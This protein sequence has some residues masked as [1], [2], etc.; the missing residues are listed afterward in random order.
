MNVSA[1]RLLWLLAALL[2][3][4]LVAEAIPGGKPSTGPVSVARPSSPQAA[5][6]AAEPVAEWVATA[7]ARPLFAPDRRP[8][9]PPA[10]AAA[11]TGPQS[12]PRLAGIVVSPGG[13]AAIF[14]GDPD[15]SL[16]VA[17][18]AAVGPWRVV[19][20]HADAVDVSGPQ[21]E[22]TVRPTYSNDPA[23]APTPAPLASGVI[24]AFMPF[25]PQDPNLAASRPAFSVNAPVATVLNRP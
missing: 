5:A 25:K 9:A 1:V 16:V 10:S 3:A 4:G 20:I 23:P 22:R 11:S 14:A 21:G 13:K 2:A 18:G 24:P 7:L 6:A 12:L 19:A 8:K 17:E 15:H